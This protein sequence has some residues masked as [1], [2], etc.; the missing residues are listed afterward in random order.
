M[1]DVAVALPLPVVPPQVAQFA[2]KHGVAAYLSGVIDVTRRIYPGRGITVHLE[3]DAE[4]ADDWC[5]MLDVD[6]A[7]LDAQQIADTQ[8]EWCSDIF[9]HCPATHVHFFRLG[10][11][12]SA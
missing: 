10:M 3:E 11:V 7:N 1:S 12:V 9:N 6:M 2:G 5:I 8:W 4:I